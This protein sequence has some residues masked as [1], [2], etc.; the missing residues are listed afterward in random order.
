MSKSKLQNL[1][2]AYIQLCGQFQ[3][4]TMVTLATNQLWEIARMTKLVGSFA[5]RMDDRGLGSAWSKLPI[6]CRANGIFFI[7]HV[8]SNIHA[9]GLVRFPYGNDWG[10]DM[11]ARKL[12]ADLCPGGSVRLSKIYTLDGAAS[13]CTKEMT[14]YNHQDEQIV[15]LEQFMSQK[16][17]SQRTK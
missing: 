15:L 9:H 5:A 17:L 13:Y 3:P 2:E 11:I 4:N 12:W 16:S 14:R 8:R 1:R 10:R 7:E 6:S